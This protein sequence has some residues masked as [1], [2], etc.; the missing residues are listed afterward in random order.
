MGR[1][2]VISEYCRSHT[3]ELSS[4]ESHPTREQYQLDCILY[5]ICEVLGA[6]RVEFDVVLGMA[7]HPK[8]MGEYD[9]DEEI[10]E[11]IAGGG[12]EK[13]EIDEGEEKVEDAEAGYTDGKVYHA[14]H[15]TL[16]AVRTAAAGAMVG[17]DFDW[18]VG[19]SIMG[20]STA[21]LV[22]ACDALRRAL[23]GVEDPAVAVEVAG[24]LERSCCRGRVAVLE[25]LAEMSTR[26]IFRPALVPFVP[27]IVAVLLGAIE[28]NC[29]EAG[30]LAEETR[31]RQWQARRFGSAG[32]TFSGGRGIFRWTDPSGCVPECQR[33]AAR[34]LCNLHIEDPQGVR[35]ALWR[36]GIGS[37]DCDDATADTYLE[38]IWAEDRR[39]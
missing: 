22:A 36:A 4:I 37:G 26:G 20:Y 14:R 32:R 12:D 25:A 38:V 29:G 6:A 3:L 8:I 21:G 39:K 15:S 17:K 10:M 31:L 27:T 13:K 11:E 35:D 7:R 34:A 1:D 18:E 23:D 33:A 28:G 2:D 24:R 9:V 19:K 16:G 30:G 5:E